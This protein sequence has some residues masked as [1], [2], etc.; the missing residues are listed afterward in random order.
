M[1]KT[2]ES[3]IHDVVR[4]VL[5]ETNQNI[6]KKQWLNRSKPLVVA[7]WKMNMTLE[8]AKDIFVQLKSAPYTHSYVVICPPFP[9]LYPMNDYCNELDIILGAQNVHEEA[10]GAH[11]GEVHVELLH[12]LGCQFVLIGHS[13]RRKSGET[14]DQIN[15]K[16]KQVIGQDLI[17]ILCVGETKEERDFGRTKNIISNQIESA[18]KDIPKEKNHFVIAYEPVWAIGTGESASP[19]EAQEIHKHIRELLIQDRSYFLAN[20]IP[21]LYGGSVNEKNI[22]DLYSMEDI[23]GVLV[24]GASLKSSSFEAI[25][26]GLQ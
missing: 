18:L 9:L 25:I 23:D 19:F 4:Q 21:I 12:E 1:G 7:N 10:K 14:N 24:G 16:I 20:Q 11:T 15:K 22:K 8:K 26:T 5:Y 17:P 2:L 13:E 6:S 3:I